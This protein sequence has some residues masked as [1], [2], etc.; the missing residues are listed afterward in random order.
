MPLSA[1]IFD[2]HAPRSR[3][4][5]L[6]HSLDRLARTDLPLLIR[7]ETGVGKEVL[8]REVH[9]QSLRAA[10]PFIA[11]NVAAHGPLEL[12]RHRH[13]LHRWPGRHGAVGR[14]GH[15]S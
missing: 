11:L 2:R 3:M 1:V 14:A 9:R 8:A 4:A 7:G 10:G 5:K 15:Q 12:L 13:A 6:M